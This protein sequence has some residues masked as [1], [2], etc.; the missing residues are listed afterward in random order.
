MDLCDIVDK[1]DEPLFSNVDPK[2][3]KEHQ[4]RMKKVMFIINL[5]LVDN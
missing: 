1:Y 5:N 4:R 3:L 2:V